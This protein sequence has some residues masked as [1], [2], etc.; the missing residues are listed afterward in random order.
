MSNCIARS[1][2]QAQ[3]WDGCWSAPGLTGSFKGVVVKDSKTILVLR[4]GDVPLKT[5]DGGTTWKRLGSVENLK[6]VG[7]GALRTHLESVLHS[8]S[9]F[10]LLAPSRHGLLLVR[11]DSRPQ[12]CVR[13]TFGLDQP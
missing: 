4:N 13:T 9:C 3:S 8:V 12:W 1:Y 7:F 2:D 10:S 6:G 11:Q 5:T